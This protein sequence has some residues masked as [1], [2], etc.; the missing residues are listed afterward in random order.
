MRP[1]HERGTAPYS[2]VLPEARLYGAGYY[3]KT[4]RRIFPHPRDVAGAHLGL[5]PFTGEHMTQPRSDSNFD[6]EDANEAL[7]RL[8]W[9][10]VPSAR[11]LWLLELRGRIQ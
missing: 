8:V 4:L 7:A 2:A 1:E 11:S 9:P 10:L 5:V 3:R 6:D